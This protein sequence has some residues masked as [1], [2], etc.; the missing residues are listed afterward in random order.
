MPS[1]PDCAFAAAN[2]SAT[3]AGS[4]SSTCQIHWRA[5]IAKLT[6]QRFI[7]S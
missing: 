1:S 2:A 6:K 3:V 7:G 5:G 4:S